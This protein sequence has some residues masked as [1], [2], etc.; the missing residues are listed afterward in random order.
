MELFM[1]NCSL[2]TP[3]T[4]AGGHTAVM[5]G[6][7][8]LANVPQ[9]SKLYTTDLN[10][11]SVCALKTNQHHD[12][13]SISL[14]FLPREGWMDGWI[15]KLQSFHPVSTSNLCFCNSLCFCCPVDCESI[16]SP[17]RA[18]CNV[19][20]AGLLLAIRVPYTHCFVVPPPQKKPKPQ[21]R[22]RKAL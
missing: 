18:G 5:E 22:R 15:E 4:G 14:K 6:W 17:E 21:P 13:T 10:T 16:C 8:C 7:T 20:G 11:A 1:D 9:P 3:S 19:I 2:I 12:S